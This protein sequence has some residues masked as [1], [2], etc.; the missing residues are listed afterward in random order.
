MT[1][2]CDNP[3]LPVVIEGTSTLQVQLNLAACFSGAPIDLS[4]ATQIT[5]Y[6]YPPG[7]ENGDV[8][9]GT[10]YTPP[11]NVEEGSA[12]F[13]ID[14]SGLTDRGIWQGGVFVNLGDEVYRMSTFF[15]LFELRGVFS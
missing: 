3:D 14:V 6:R 4:T 13:S 12:V 15:P 11:A 1:Y 9:F 7:W 8:T 10:Q 2:C 5:L